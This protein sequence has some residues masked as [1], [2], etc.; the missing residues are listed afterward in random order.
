M[1]KLIVIEGL[2]GSGKSTQLELMKSRYDAHFITFPYYETDS[3]RMISAYLRGDFN[4]PDPKVSA[5]SASIMYAADRYTSFRTHWGPLY[6]SG[7]PVISA[8]YV[9]SNAIYQM[10]KLDRSEWDSYLDWLCDLEYEKLGM[11]RPDLTIFLDMPGDISQKLLL[12][13]Y[14]GDESK[15]DIHERDISFQRR[16]REAAL[17]TA[18]RFGWKRV[19]CGEN[20]E[21]FRAETIG[22]AIS[23]L[24]DEELKN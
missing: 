6:E 20:G 9:S 8:R 18:E 1:K 12:K 7:L 10:T 15:K 24:I 16:C 13:R 14:G 19:L 4:E 2:D 17:Y 11:P 23:A 21:P 3:G 22:S 5:Y